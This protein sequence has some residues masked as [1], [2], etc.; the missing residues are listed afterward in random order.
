[1][2]RPIDPIPD[3][4]RGAGLVMVILGLPVAAMP[5]GLSFG[6]HLERGIGFTILGGSVAVLPSMLPWLAPLAAGTFVVGLGLYFGRLV[7][8]GL[9]VA[10]AWML[11][12]AAFAPTVAFLS[13]ILAYSI[14]TGQR[15]MA[16]ASG[17]LSSAAARGPLAP[18]TR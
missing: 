1:M 13:A 11:G 4:I 2:T 10:L 15:R 7:R 16:A 9:V 14:W 5:V 18:P 17:G 12:I 3:R 6:A 8:E